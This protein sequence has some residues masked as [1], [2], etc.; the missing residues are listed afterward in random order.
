MGGVRVSSPQYTNPRPI[1][2]GSNP[3]HFVG[4]LARTWYL[5]F[6]DA[7]GTS[8]ALAGHRCPPH[9]GPAASFSPLPAPPLRLGAGPGWRRYMAEGRD[10]SGAV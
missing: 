9:E 2:A 8:R 10:Y 5:P 6:P 4:Y 1:Q 7:P 3:G